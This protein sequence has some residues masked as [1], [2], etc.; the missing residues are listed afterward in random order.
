MKKILKR[1][2]SLLMA[3][4]LICTTF[5][6]A[7]ALEPILETENVVP[8][9]QPISFTVIP[10]SD[11][12]NDMTPDERFASCLVSEAE[13]NLL[14]TEA[15]VESVLNY[16]YLLNVYAY[17]TL[18]EGIYAVSEYFPGLNELFSRED[19]IEVL[20]SVLD[21]ANINDEVNFDTKTIYALTLYNYMQGMKT[22]NEKASGPAWETK[23]KY[24]TTPGGYPVA[25]FEGLTWAD[26]LIVEGTAIRLT[27]EYLTLYPSARIVRSASPKYNCHSYVWYST[28]SGNQYWMDD[29][30]MY[31]YDENYNEYTTAAVNR[32]VT[33]T[34][35][36]DSEQIVHSGI[37]TAKSGSDITVTSK[38]GYTSLFSHDLDDCPYYFSTVIKYWN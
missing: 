31:T 13:V 38:W 7:F 27:N 28:G 32:K 20:Q 5:S 26:H 33:Y 10:G 21:V 18:E 9:N 17:N 14:T 4:V 16:P 23:L 12:W 11:E 35:S 24:I 36:R 15:L 25:V 8:S 3:I 6:G 34:N 19:A 2:L 1:T 29:P 22:I 37:V 30:I